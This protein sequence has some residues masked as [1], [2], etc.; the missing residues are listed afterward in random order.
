[1]ET[2]FFDLD[3][4]ITDSGKG[5]IRSVQY[6]LT[7]LNCPLPDEKRLKQFIGPPL[8]DSFIDYIGLT[9]EKA[10]QAIA[11]Y[12]DYF[13]DKGMFENDVYE[14]IP[15]LLDQLKKEH[16]QI[17][18]TT[19]KPE[20]YATL[21]LQH[22]HLEHYF[23]G[24]YGASMDG[25]LNKKGDIIK[26]ALETE[27]TVSLNTTIMVGD[28]KY[29]ILGA[30]ENQLKSIGVLYGFGSL[31]ELKEEHADYIVKTPLDILRLV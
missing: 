17:F 3:G 13:E 7:T 31:E 2:V 29:D 18:L 10:Q 21:I 4:T 5:I 11:L 12:R 27:K 24:I 6:A 23:D 19:S 30:K 20:K 25:T 28:R 9:K 26:K 14:G 16:K 22:F 8:L 15:E 1:M